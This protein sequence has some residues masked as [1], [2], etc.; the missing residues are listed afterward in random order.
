MF[1]DKGAKEAGMIHLTHDFDRKEFMCLYEMYA[2]LCNP[3][4]LI[5]RERLNVLSHMAIWK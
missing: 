2:N 5:V 1:K 4:H 3:M